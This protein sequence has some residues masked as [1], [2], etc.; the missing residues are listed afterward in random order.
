MARTLIIGSAG[1][2]ELYGTAGDDDIIAGGGMDFVFGGA[3][4]DFILGEGGIDYLDGEDGD[5]RLFGGDDNDVLRG[6]QGADLVSGDA[7]DDWLSGGDGRSPDTSYD[8]LLGG[9]GNDTIYS[10]NADL[11]DGGSGDDLAVLLRQDSNVAFK[12]DFSMP[13]RAQTLADGTVIT[14]VER[15]SFSGGSGADILRAGDGADEL[16]GGGGNDQLWGG[17]GIDILDGGS[18]RDRLVG[19]EGGDIFA[20]TY[21]TNRDRIID[22]AQGE[23]RIAINGLFAT[24]TFDKIV[25]ATSRDA[26]TGIVTIDLS[27]IG[28][29]PSDRIELLTDPAQAFA[30]TA[31]DFLL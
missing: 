21:G 4:S 8:Q 11:I 5:D 16:R 6:G 1:D 18:G 22:F 3:G 31:A 30:F 23:D 29:A 17:G 2:D 7:G 19:G 28:G 15:V 26:A 13:H 12:A 10:E 24:V 9:A 20:F 25:A 27:Q 14:G